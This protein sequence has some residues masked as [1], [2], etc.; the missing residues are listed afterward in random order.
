MST[1][2]SS[3]SW[4]ARFRRST[5]AGALAPSAGLRNRLVHE[6]ETIDDAK[7]LASVD[8]LLQLYPRYIQAVESYLTKAGL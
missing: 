2:I 8:V 1:L 7:V 4:A 3:R 5:T 6:Y